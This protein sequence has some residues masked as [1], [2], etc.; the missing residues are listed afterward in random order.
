VTA[1]NEALVCTNV[2]TSRLGSG[3]GSVGPCQASVL[4][5]SAVTLAR[6]SVSGFG[7]RVRVRLRY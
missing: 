1:R 7:I 3:T 2:W 6:G 5:F 4:G